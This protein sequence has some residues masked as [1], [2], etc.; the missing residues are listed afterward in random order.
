MEDGMDATV[1][2]ISLILFF[3]LP[4]I[5]SL[6]A[7]LEACGGCPETPATS[8]ALMRLNTRSTVGSPSA[9]ITKRNI[10]PVSRSF[11]SS[12]ESSSLCSS[13]S[14]S[15]SPSSLSLGA[16]FVKRAARSFGEW[17]VPFEYAMPRRF[18]SSL[19]GGC[20]GG[21]GGVR[22][23]VEA[24]EAAATDAAGDAAVQSQV[25]E[26]NADFRSFSASSVLIPTGGG[27]RVWCTLPDLLASRLSV[28]AT[29]SSLLRLKRERMLCERKSCRASSL[30]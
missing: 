22:G 24:A 19:I 14:S 29:S 9:P 18:A 1:V 27:W 13:S 3:A 17:L 25:V 10:S 16:P 5:R 26:D 21:G 12:V 20:G 6:A 4:I 30:L 2:A 7:S 23:R 28:H 11:S 15:S 8:T